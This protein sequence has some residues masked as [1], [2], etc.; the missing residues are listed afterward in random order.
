MAPTATS[1]E[2]YVESDEAPVVAPP[3]PA[4]KVAMK[5]FADAL[6]ERGMSEMAASAM[7]AAVI[8]P[9]DARKKLQ[10]PSEMRVPGAI[11]EFI[12]TPAWAPRLVTNPANARESA[13]HVLPITGQEMDFKPLGA[14]RPLDGRPELTVEVES[15]EQLVAA[16]NFSKSFLLE[17]NSYVDSISEQGVLMPLTVGAITVTHADKRPPTILL[18]SHDGSSRVASTHEILSVEPEDAAYLY[19][20]NDRRFRQLVAETRALLDQPALNAR[21]QAK[22]RSLVVPATFIVGIKSPPGHDGPPLD[23]AKAITAFVGQVHVEPPKEWGP[24]AELDVM[25]E[26]VLGELIDL[27]VITEGERDFFA[28][29]MTRGQARAAGLSDEL[30]ERA[31]LILRYALNSLKAVR[32]GVRRVVPKPKVPKT[33]V[34]DVCAE[35]AIRAYRTAQNAGNA[36]MSR[37]ALQRVFRRFSGAKAITWAVTGRSPEELRDAALKELGVDPKPGPATAELALM[38]AYH[39]T[40]EHVLR[41]PDRAP[42][43]NALGK[44]V[45]DIR[46][47]D[48]V[49]LELA[50][51]PR[52]IHFLYQA[53]VDGRGGVEP[54]M[55]DDRGALVFDATSHAREASHKWL[56]LEVSPPSSEAEPTPPLDATLTETIETKL[57]KARASYARHVE[58]AEADMQA[59]RTI[60]GDD[61][62]AAIDEMG[63]PIGEADDLLRRLQRMQ[64]ALYGWRMRWTVRNNVSDDAEDDVNGEVGA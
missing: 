21:E 54:R 33:L 9:A 44:L 46:E 32:R 39:L 27:A 59:V 42:M 20:L 64:G 1:E 13:G 24:G 28:G 56:R 48:D 17:H 60:V 55:V 16:L 25:G 57:A 29:L 14:L 22:I 3:D 52:G 23:M 15:A 34:A 26:A 35:L 31:A 40:R 49:L 12:M 47:P 53:V 63:W 4:R 8:D 7:A 11:I 18:V 5:R 43:V 58:I 50:R 36:H 41:R 45:P 2:E 61:G 6:V 19:P 51:T 30:D 37:V 38:A 62:H 10:V